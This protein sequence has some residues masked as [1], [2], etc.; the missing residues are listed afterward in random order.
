MNKE[1][2]LTLTG[3]LLALF[4]GALDQT[5]VATALPKI[6]EDLNGLERYSLVATSYLMCSTTLVPIYGKLADMFSRRLIELVAVLIFLAG[7]FL[8]GISGE[9]GNLPFIGDGMNQLIFF[10]GIQGIGGAGLF[11]MAFI[12]I[13]DLFP[14]AERGKYQG[15][16]GATFG[17]ASVLGPWLGGMLTDYGGAFIT[18]IEGWRWVFYVN[19]P[20]G[21]LALTFILLKM[22]RLQPPA[23]SL[24]FD[25]KGAIFLVLA[26]APLVLGLEMDKEKYE[27]WSPQVAGLFILSFLSVILF[28]WHSRRSKNPVL[29]LSL[30]RNKVFSWSIISLFL[31]GITFFGIV[32]FMPLFLVNVVGVSPTKA[33]V[34]MIP[35][36]LG[37]VAGSIVAGQLVSRFGHYRRWMLGGI[38]ILTLGFYILSTFGTGVRYIEVLL[39]MAL[40]GLGIGPT[41]PLYPLAIQNAVSRTEIGQSTSAAQFFRQIGGTIG[42]ALMGAIF[43]L[44]L[45]SFLNQNIPDEYI[46]KKMISLEEIRSGGKRA[47][48][49]GLELYF[50]Q[51][52]EESLDET[53]EQTSGKLEALEVKKQETI[54]KL[55]AELTQAFQFSITRIYRYAIIATILTFITTLIIPE[56]KL[57]KTLEEVQTAEKVT[58][59]S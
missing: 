45:T 38:L 48:E 7:S 18:G 44:S 3:I 19:V 11:A 15:Y 57:K 20:F 5:I 13:A 1:K 26:I 52:I 10:R 53:G 55:D 4:L 49:A 2:S 23:S 12:I 36:S 34:S 27:L 46:E 22:P 31:L 6:V 43:T 25:W 41:M 56:L 16:V 47:A 54:D 29:N 28:I 8:C 33:G 17:I 59:G 32:I 21:I 40:C 42:T 9:F 58:V 30:F 24:K 37:L 50:D 39:T 14:P 35:L 51:R